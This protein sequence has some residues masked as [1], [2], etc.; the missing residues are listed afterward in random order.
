VYDTIHPSWFGFGD[1]V[2]SH[3]P[4]RLKSQ[5]GAL[6]MS[7]AK[8]HITMLGFITSNGE[9]I[10]RALIFAAK[11]MKDEWFFDLTLLLNK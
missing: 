8:H 10:M 3:P 9:P 5:W 1:E 6:L 2:G 11:A 7:A 4:K